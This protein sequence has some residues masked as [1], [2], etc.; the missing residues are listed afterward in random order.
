MSKQTEKLDVLIIGAGIA[1]LGMAYNMLKNRKADSFAVIE[2]RDNIGGTWDYFKYPGLRTDS[3]MY[4]YAYSFKPWRSSEY[5]GSAARLMGYL[6]E[7]VEEHNI[8]EK[9]RFQTRITS[10]DWSSKTNTWT[11]VATKGDGSSYLI[12]TKFL[13][14]C[15]GY[16]DYE[17]GYLPKFEGYDDFKGDIIHTQK[18]PENYDYK[19]KN[20]VVI[21]SGATAFTIVPTMAKDT[22]HITMLQ[23][24]PGYV[25]SRPSKDGLYDFLSKFLPASVTNRIMRM[26]YLSLLG[27]IYALSKGF[28]NFTRKILI[29]GVRKASNNQI[30]V[31]K[32]LTPNYK[33]WDQRVCMVPNNDMF[34]AI[35][36]G[37]ASIETEQ[38]KRFTKKG[39]L[40]KNG[41]ELNA[42]LIVT[43]TGLKMQFWGG[44][45]VSVDSNPVPPNSVTNYKG[46]MF[47]QL[48]NMITVFGSTTSSWT[49]KAEICYDYICRLLNFMEDKKFKSVFP[50]LTETGDS[51]NLVSL[52]SGYV[53]RAKNDLPKQ[54]ASFP[55]SSKDF[56][57]TD[58]L[59]IKR[60][61]LDDGVLVFDKNS[62]L[63]GFHESQEVV[64]LPTKKAARA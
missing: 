54:G 12:E 47:S 43:A 49:V 39:I 34:E 13:I 37:D 44:M 33:P 20:V 14:A 3:D 57:F 48:P 36:S 9:I 16:Y 63:S 1:G 22:A 55:W 5:I 17:G 30:D 42:D 21:G 40:L 15:T 11:L 45:K 38:I 61:K 64:D 19:N 29:N 25:F 4:T 56:Y 53:Q 6:N 28:P 52:T 35:K 31:N 51:K 27:A 24:S 32:H 50:Y 23:R 58:L 41:D 60:S 7:M 10:A 46:M 59:K 62:L 8:E 18:W 26:K 2:S